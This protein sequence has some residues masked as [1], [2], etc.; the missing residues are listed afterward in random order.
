MRFESNE[1]LF[2]T[3][4]GK[5]GAL[6]VPQGKNNFK[7]YRFTIGGRER[8]KQNNWKHALYDDDIMWNVQKATAV[9]LPQQWHWL[10]ERTHMQYSHKPTQFLLLHL[11]VVTKNCKDYLTNIVQNQQC[12]HWNFFC[13]RWI[14][15][16]FLIKNGL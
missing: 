1:L 14:F 6:L 7:P 15:K 11:L 16:H 8:G 5:P 2:L 10:G 12:S 4:V 3:S 13:V 9:C